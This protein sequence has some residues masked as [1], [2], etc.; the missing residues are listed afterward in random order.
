[1]LAA[2]VLAVGVLTG[3]VL[4]TQ[5]KRRRT[6]F[7]LHIRNAGNIRDRYELWTEAADAIKVHF[8]RDGVPLTRREIME[9]ISAAE[10]VAVPATGA[11]APG[12]PVASGREAGIGSKA[13]KASG[14]VRS[15]A[16]GLMSLSSILPTSIRSPIQ[17]VLRT[18]YQGEAKVRQV[19]T[20][21]TR[22]SRTVSR[23]KPSGA[24]PSVSQQATGAPPVAAPAGQITRTA[25]VTRTVTRAG[26]QTPLVEP[27]EHLGVDIVIDPIKQHYKSCDYL[28]KVFSRSIDLE[29]ASMV[30]AQES[31]QIQG[32]SLF[33]RIFPF[34]LIYG[35]AL[36]SLGI[37]WL[38]LT[39]L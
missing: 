32:V 21:S 11:P 20:A 9:T 23:V 10:T 14:F 22:V 17:R 27:D 1:V 30:I 26:Y 25:H 19:S 39:G 18:W 8:A 15:I 4:S 29:D 13:K 6:I 12:T 7:Q 35:V 16:Q 38:V 33:R 24:R 36:L 2:I 34:L 5:R 28:L 3:L 37:L 31:I